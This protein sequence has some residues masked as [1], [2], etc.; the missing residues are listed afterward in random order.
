MVLESCQ[1]VRPWL[2]A[3]DMLTAVS[4]YSWGWG[5]CGIADT[6]NRDLG[7][8]S[9][10]TWVWLGVCEGRSAMWMLYLLG[11]RQAM[12]SEAH[13][14]SLWAMS[15]TW[16]TL[17]T[18][19]PILSHIWQTGGSV[20]NSLS[21][22]VTL[23][24]APWILCHSC[25]V[26]TVRTAAF[27]SLG[28]FPVTHDTARCWRPQCHVSRQEQCWLLVES[29]YTCLR[30]HWW[31]SVDDTGSEATLEHSLHFC[32]L[33]SSSFTPSPLPFFFVHPLR[34]S[35]LVWPGRI[36]WLYSPGWPKPCCISQDSTTHM[37]FLIWAPKCWN[38]SP[39]TMVQ[40]QNILWS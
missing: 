21:S 23:P 30:D 37:L 22:A 11:T 6:S 5:L 16:V 12:D 35:A 32:S 28:E 24:A 18:G 17:V 14:G 33:S 34:S 13:W 26:N 19:N 39:I 9:M 8:W 25:V 7:K 3:W 27:L 29:C 4:P 36:S 1:A 31:V 20:P 2:R 15:S 10:V 38:C 40:A